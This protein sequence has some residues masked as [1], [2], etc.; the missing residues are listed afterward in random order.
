MWQVKVLAGNQR[1]SGEH[2]TSINHNTNVTYNNSHAVATNIT[3]VASHN[4]TSL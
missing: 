2:H 3:S 4:I 1:G